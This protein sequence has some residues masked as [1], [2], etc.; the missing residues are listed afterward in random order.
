MAQSI[1]MYAHIKSISARVDKSLRLSMETPELTSN[2]RAVLMDLQGINLD[3][4]L[5]PLD[6]EPEGLIEIDKELE[7]KSSS[8]RLRNVLFLLWRQ[9]GSDGEFNS[10][11]KST[12]E[13]II[14]HFKNKLEN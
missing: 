14:S 2:E 10:F 7:Q 6:T 1:K 12:Y 9:N 11:Y 4:L 13:K 5:K 8:Q 3:V